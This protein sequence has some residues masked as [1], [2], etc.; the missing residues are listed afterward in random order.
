MNFDH[1]TVN[2]VL[3]IKPI[4]HYVFLMQ[5]SVAFWH[6]WQLEDQQLQADMLFKRNYYLTIDKN[7]EEV[8]F[9]EA[10]FHLY[11]HI[12]RLWY[13]LSQSLF[14]KYVFSL[15]QH[16]VTVSTVTF[17]NG[18][19]WRNVYTLQKVTVTVTVCELNL[20]VNY[21]VDVV[22]LQTQFTRR[23]TRAFLN[24]IT[25]LGLPYGGPLGL[26]TPEPRPRL[27]DNNINRRNNNNNNN[28]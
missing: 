9:I 22:V 24:F 28:K 11:N 27:I 26:P 2:P 10:E 8:A 5:N 19:Q 15:T 23:F 6:Y 1:L 25:V 13:N 12:K 17:Y 20:N 16:T 3:H 4:I 14:Q 7:V 18:D 21:N